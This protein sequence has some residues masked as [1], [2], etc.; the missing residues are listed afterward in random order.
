MKGNNTLQLNQAT[1]NEAIAYYLNNCV[2]GQ[3]FTAVVKDVKYQA[4]DLH[5]NPGGSFE[6]SFVSEDEESAGGDQTT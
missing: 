4:R 3:H 6:V 2:F 1:M 5:L